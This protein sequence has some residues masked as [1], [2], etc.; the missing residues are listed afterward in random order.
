LAKN[1]DG[2]TIVSIET[3]YKLSTGDIIGK[4]EENG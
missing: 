4:I 1:K 3:I 2:I